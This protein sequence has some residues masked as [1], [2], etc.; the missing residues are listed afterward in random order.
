MNW[1][2]IYRY[3]ILALIVMIVAQG[4]FPHLV[5]AAE[6]SRS[7]EESY[8]LMVVAH[9]ILLEEDVDDGGDIAGGAAVFSI[10]RDVPPDSP[11]DQILVRLINA[12]KKELG[13]LEQTCKE[14][15]TSFSEEGQEC[16][17]VLLK[18]YCD[19]QIP[20]LRIRL[21]L[22]RKVRG[23][24]R[25]GITK[26]W[27][28]IK[29]A[30]ARLWRSV[31][32]IGRRFLRELGNDVHA[33]VKS[34]GSLHGGVLRR[35]V[36]KHGGAMLRHAV[37]QRL[38]RALN[39]VILGRVQTA[40][41]ICV[42]SDESD[43]GG[44]DQ[45][46]FSESDWFEEVWSYMEEL[47][48]NERKNCQTSAIG[49]LRSCLYEKS[50]AGVSAEEGINACEPLLKAI[51]ANDAGGAVSLQGVTYYG[52]AVPNDVFITYPSEGGA[53]N[54]KVDFQRYDDVFGCT[55]TLHAT[56]QGEYD[57]STC[58]MHGTAMVTTL[59][60]GYCVNVCGDA[61]GFSTNCPVTFNREWRWEA[62]LEDGLLRGNIVGENVDHGYFDFRAPGE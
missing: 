21:S 50:R 35:L 60:E 6:V 13:D 22:L 30:G 40:G 2:N 51:P 5:S 55:Y 31:G 39:R 11:A 17:D 59:H 9:G 42:E 29:R 45:I 62:S 32:P 1:R 7:M 38:K 14:L 33:V 41:D 49:E 57:R 19:S 27:H 53:V 16:E 24:R 34:G 46:Q 44:L 54:G 4:V 23:D 12:T 20:K 8:D 58:S 61:P 28:A 52:D 25:K 37:R 10:R 48:I 36:I 15:R 3:S 43:E 26:A 56:L 47:L 18:A